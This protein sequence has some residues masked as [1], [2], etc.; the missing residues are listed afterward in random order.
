MVFLFDSF[1]VAIKSFGAVPIIVSIQNIFTFKV[2]HSRS[3]PSF[4]NLPHQKRWSSAFYL[5]RVKCFITLNIM[6]WRCWAVFLCITVFLSYQ[7][8]PVWPVY[9]FLLYN[10][11]LKIEHYNMSMVKIQKI[12][13]NTG[14]YSI[15]VQRK[16][17]TRPWWESDTTQIEIVKAG[18][19]QSLTVTVISQFISVILSRILGLKPILN[20]ISAQF[21]KYGLHWASKRVRLVHSLF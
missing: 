1:A 6:W 13:S 12:F 8:R 11:E 4:P 16:K 7:G 5:L 9:V 15:L 10:M 14:R 17:S 20:L 21:W 18:I 19:V 3:K 2:L